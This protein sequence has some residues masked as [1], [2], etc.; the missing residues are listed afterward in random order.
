MM[1]K[2]KLTRLLGIDVPIIQGPFGG[3]LS[4]TS[5]AS[6]VSNA[7]GLGSF[8]AHMMEP[9]AIPALCDEM[10]SLTRRSFAVNLW[11]SD[12]DPEQ[13]ELTRDRF[14]S[15]VDSLKDTYQ[16]VGSSPPRWEGVGSSTFEQQAEALIKA[17]PKAFSFVF[18]IPSEE[19]LKEC[20]RQGIVTIGAATTLDEALAIEAAGIDA[21]VVTGF[22]AGGH[23]PSFLKRSEDS[24]HGT[25]ALVPVIKDRVAI[26][27]IAAGGI[28]DARGVRAAL[29][30]GADA[31]QLGTAFLACEESGAPE[32]HKQALRRPSDTPTVL[33][34]A[35]TG[36][37]ARFQENQ[38]VREFEAAEA[39]ALPFPA[40]S[41]VM[42]PIKQAAAASGNLDG[43]S[44]YASQSAPLI[45]H[46]RAEDLMHSLKE[47]FVH[48]P[49]GAMG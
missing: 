26:P 8:G 34:R 21:M 7:G 33:S 14:E 35:F 38:V 20:K 10:R 5:L 28:A 32:V 12:R 47:V 1:A 45:K 40:Q 36:R 23:R 39:P 24:L 27:V 25:L 2:N 42:G 31:A 16:R 46:H 44:L 13:D 49:A 22:E 4:T 3:G 17:R 9:D 30:L 29:A 41:W 11:V 18:G 6:T 19:I 15:R 43:M 37:L 48:E